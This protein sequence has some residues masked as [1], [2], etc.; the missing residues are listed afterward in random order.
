METFNRFRDRVDDM[1]EREREFAANLDHEIRTPLTTIRTDAELVGLEADLAPQQRQR[2]ERIAA[3]GRRDHRHDRVDAVVQRRPLR[4]RRDGRPA[5]VPARRR[6]GDGRP[7]RGE[8]AA[9][10]RRRRR[11]RSDRGRSPGAADDRAQPAPQ[12]HRARRAGDA[13]HRRRSHAPSSSATTARASTRR[14]SSGSS[15]A[16]AMPTRPAGA[17]RA[18][19]G[20]AASAW[21]SPSASATCRA[22]RSRCARRSIPGA[23]RRSRS[24]WGM[25]RRRRADVRPHHAFSTFLARSRHGAR[26]MLAA[27]GERSVLEGTASVRP[28]SGL[29]HNPDHALQRRGPGS[30]PWTISLPRPALKRPCGLRRD[31][32][33]V[34]LRRYVGIH[35]VAVPVVLAGLAGGLPVRQRSTWRSR[36]CSSIPRRRAS[37]G[38]TRPSST[39]SATRR[40][41][42]LPFLVGAFA[43]AAGVAGLRLRSLRPWTPILLTDRRGDAHRPARRQ[44][45]QGHDHPALSGRLQSFG[46]VVDYLAEPAGSVLGRLGAERRPLPAERP[47]RRRLRAAVAV[48]RRLGRRPAR[49][50][51]GAAWRSASPPGCCSASSA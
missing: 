43:I 37:P 15:R 24:A 48:L 44:P 51:A 18:A 22:G 11:R 35:L 12:R 2:L 26:P 38:V 30:P 36:A 6:R 45:A 23:A 50:G 3:V 25:A 29:L 8:G 16:P 47:R 21:R 17:T 33:R 32:P 19:R 13:A 49:A 9:H 28:A 34:D 20:C 4:R 27:M 46:G 5:R 39:S 42:L 14:G 41:R 10:R 40:A 7:R 1:V 31:R